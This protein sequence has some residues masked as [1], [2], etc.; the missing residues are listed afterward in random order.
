MTYKLSYFY[1]NDYLHIEC[2]LSTFL[3]ACG[4]SNLRGSSVDDL[5][6]GRVNGLCLFLDDLMSVLAMSK[7]GH[8]LCPNTDR[9]PLFSILLQHGNDLC[10]MVHNELAEA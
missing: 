4:G 1:L 3:Q 6:L 8:N 2:A 10:E 7:S 5:C 9:R